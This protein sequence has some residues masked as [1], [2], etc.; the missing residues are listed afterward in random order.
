M[1]SIFWDSQG[2]IMIDYLVQGLTINGA[3]YIGILRRLHQK[4]ARKR[5]GKLTWGVL[6]L[7]D[8]AP[9]HTLQVTMTAATECEFKILPP[10][11]YSLD[12]APSSDFYLFPKLKTST[13]YTV[14]KQ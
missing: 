10:S 13:W 12:I 14:W 9:A 8:N 3:Y 11:L 6:L 4:I 7:Q 5:Q 2:V 1:A